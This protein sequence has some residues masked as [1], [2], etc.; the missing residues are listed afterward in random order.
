[1]VRFRKGKIVNRSRDTASLR[2][3]LY[4][5]C[6]LLGSHYKQQR[7][8]CQFKMLSTKKMASTIIFVAGG[9]KNA[10]NL[11]ACQKKAFKEL[12]QIVRF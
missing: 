10:V 11:L 6:S 7:G 5:L 2:W 12:S 3:P 1:M 8:N 9:S 4:V